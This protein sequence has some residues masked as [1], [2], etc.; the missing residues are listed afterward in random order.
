MRGIYVHIPFCRKRCLYCDFFTV[1]ERLADWPRY[2]ESILREARFRL[3]PSD[4]ECT[5]YIGGGTPSLMPDAEFVRL[6]EG[7]FELVPHISEFTIEVNPDDVTPD[8]AALW[9]ACGIDRISMGIQSLVDAELKAIGRRHDAA[10]ALKA[11]GILRRFFTNISVDIIFGLPLQTLDSLQ[12]STDGLLKLNPE[13]ISA[14]SLMYEERSALTKMLRNGML[15]PVTEEDS[16]DMFSYLNSRL[17]EGGYEQ[18]EISN[19]C[20]NGFKSR[21]NSLYWDGSPYVGLGAGAHG[22]DGV[23]RRFHNAEDIRRYIEYW[24]N[25]GLEKFE[26]THYRITETEILE[27]SDLRE[28]MIM[29][30]LRIREGI[31]LR[32]FESKFGKKSLECLLKDAEKFIQSGMMIYKDGF[33]SLSKQGIY[34]SDH[35]ISSLF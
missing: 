7:I 35:I 6:V 31:C 18:Y 25:T 22:F 34:L 4:R 21:H 17:L 11:Y 20:R 9:K 32:D 14:Y 5:L 13:H 16:S 15:E 19:Y 29:T 26:S 3:Q 24:N 8:K 23:N 1:G 33:L 28:E 27:E 12:T 10:T 2:V 30:R